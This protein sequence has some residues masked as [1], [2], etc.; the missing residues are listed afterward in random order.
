MKSIHL[1][2][3][4][5]LAQL[6]YDVNKFPGHIACDS[7][8]RSEIVVPIIHDGDVVGVLDIDCPEV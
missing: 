4:S 6:V 1:E 5:D 3:T 2:L 8:S 7:A